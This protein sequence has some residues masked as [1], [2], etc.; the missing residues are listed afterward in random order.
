LSKL[1]SEDPDV[2]IIW[3]AFELRPEPVPTLDPDG[4][5]LRNA[6]NNSVYPLAEKLGVYMKLPP[7]QPRTR[8]AHE[9]AH[10]ARSKGHFDEYNA[11]VF[12]AFF[13]RGTDIGRVDVLVGLASALGMDGDALRLSLKTREYEEQVLINEEEAKKHGIRA[14]PAFVVEGRSILTG[15]QPVK[16]L[17]ALVSGIRKQL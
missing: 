4:D 7:V 17:R 5:Y 16:Q 11:A 8:R 15:V 6:W 14:V 9:A 1:A 12:G 10:W 2:E 13:E 3:C